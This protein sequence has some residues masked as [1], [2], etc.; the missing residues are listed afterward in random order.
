MLTFGGGRRRAAEATASLHAAE[1]ALRGAQERPE[2]QGAPGGRVGRG[3]ST[4]QAALS[5]RRR[6]LHVRSLLA[7]M[8][9]LP[10]G[11]N[12]TLEI[13]PSWPIKIAW[14]KQRAPRRRMGCRQGEG[15]KEATVRAAQRQW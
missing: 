9:L 6:T 8:I 4:G 12:E 3:P 14:Q 10:C 7:V 11:L 2:P 15:E 5:P 1:A 13:S